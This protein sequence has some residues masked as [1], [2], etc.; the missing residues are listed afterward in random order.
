MPDDTYP[1][2]K[3]IMTI[4]DCIERLPIDQQ[5]VAESDLERILEVYKRGITDPGYAQC[6]QLAKNILNKWYRNKYGIETTYDAEGRF[7]AGWKTLQR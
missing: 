4:M 7:D 6:Q 3:I 5:L 1:N 2:A